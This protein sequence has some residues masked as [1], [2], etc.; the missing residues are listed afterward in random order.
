MSKHTAVILGLEHR[1]QQCAP[2]DFYLCCYREPAH[3]TSLKDFL[4]A[5][6]SMFKAA[7]AM[8]GQ[9]AGKIQSFIS[10]EAEAVS[11]GKLSPSKRCPPPLP[12]L[13]ELQLKK[14]RQHVLVLDLQTA[15]VVKG[16]EE[17]LAPVFCN[18]ALTDFSSRWGGK[19]ANQPSIFAVVELP[20]N[21]PA[22]SFYR[23]LDVTEPAEI[24][25]KLKDLTVVWPGGRVAFFGIILHTSAQV[26]PIQ[27]MLK[28]LDPPVEPILTLIVS[29][30]WQ[31]PDGQLDMTIPAVMRITTADP[32]Q[33]S[34]SNVEVCL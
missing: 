11:E 23:Q 30:Q 26:D 32:Y 16:K 18:M 3:S 19:T 9:I 34:A 27:K 17:S 15:E 2:S 33:Y 10:L 8:S 5:Y 31:K 24:E 7:K 12:L 13:P 14:L 1:A 20:E 22:D 6:E 21:A 28:Q 29:V 4:S 25:R